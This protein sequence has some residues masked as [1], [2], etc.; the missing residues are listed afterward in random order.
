VSSDE[1][2]ERAGI[3]RLALPTP[4]AVGRV[5]AYLIE[6]DPLTLIDTGPNSADALVELA[7]D[8]AEHGHRVEDLGLIVVTHS[9]WT[10]SAWS[11]SS[12]SALARRSPHLTCSAPGWLRFQPRW[13]P[14]TPTP[15]S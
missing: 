13:R 4:F 14:T 8:L 6:D 7:R 15:N 11:T 2:L 5:N 12:P 9:T 10:T 3:R 1:L